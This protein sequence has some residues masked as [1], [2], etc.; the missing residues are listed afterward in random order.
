MPGLKRGAAFQLAGGFYPSLGFASTLLTPLQGI[1]HSPR[2]TPSA[3]LISYFRDAQRLHSLALS[4]AASGWVR[5]CILVCLLPETSA[6]DF[7]VGQSFVSARSSCPSI[8]AFLGF[9]FGL[10]LFVIIA[11]TPGIISSRSP[12][13]RCG[14]H[15]S[16]WTFRA[17]IAFSI[18][19]WIYPSSFTSLAPGALLWGAA[20][21]G[22]VTFHEPQPL[23]LAFLVSQVAAMPLQPLD[24]NEV[25]RAE[26]RASV[27][28]VADRVVRRQTRT[29]REQLLD[30]FNS[31]LIE[32][33]SLNIEE[34]V[35]RR[36]ADPE[37]I[38]DWLVTYG[39][40]LYY[41]G[42]AYGRFSE[43]INA[44]ASRRPLFRRQLTGAWDSAFSWVADE[45]SSHHPAV[46]LTL[47]L[48]TCSL[49][50]LW[51]WAKESAIFLMT[52]CGVLRIGETLNARRSDLVL[53]CDG[54]PGRSFALLQIRQPKTRGVAAKHQS[55]R[56]DPTD[57]VQLLTSVFGRLNR[58]E[59]LWTA[60]SAV[61]RR[62]FVALQK[63]PGLP[64]VKTRS[65]STYDLASLRP[66]GATH[67]TSL[68]MQTSSGDV[69][70][71]CLQEFVKY[72]CKR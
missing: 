40:E 4:R 18:S 38:S 33:A 8:L 39:R 3:S 48:A 1:D 35:D 66:G 43:T 16:T 9:L 45:P 21:R 10:A 60:S 56:I 31:W 53:P 34:L 19:A 20:A 36:D 25:R 51:G 52:W 65:S 61:L 23:P 2:R 71:G 11:C 49:S 72:I 24:G 64:T 30:Q 68:R 26:R 70:V 44:V 12:A 55:A 50:L 32:K 59:M 54:V 58:D 63:A 28:L 41:A 14:F 47:L 69:D 6:F 22:K 7:D 27:R 15:F 29:R 46:P 57:V 17:V 37:T 67:F 62:R 42:K 13:C 5:L